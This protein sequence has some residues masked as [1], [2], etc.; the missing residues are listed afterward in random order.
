MRQNNSMFINIL[1]R[2]RKAIH[3]VHDIDVI[4][5]LYLKEPP[6]GSKIPYLF[7]TNK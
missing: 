2:F 7:Y 3:T 1:N 4:N 6:K 5:N